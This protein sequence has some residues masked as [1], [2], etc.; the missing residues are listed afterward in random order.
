MKIDGSMP[1]IIGMGKE[2]TAQTKV[3]DDRFQVALEKAFNKKD[4]EQLREACREFERLFMDML[5]KQMKKT[6]MRSDLI[7]ESFAHQTFSSMLDEELVAKASMGR[8]T[9]LGEMLFK[10][11]SMQMNNQ[12]VSSGSGQRMN[13]IE[14]EGKE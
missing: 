14:D 8:G 12:Y 11:L 2:K 7:K 10:Q 1:G 5:Y 6:V 3:Q 9:G 4:E 13:R